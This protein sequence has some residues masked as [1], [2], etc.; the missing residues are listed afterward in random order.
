MDCPAGLVD[1][2]AGS[3]RFVPHFHLPLQHASDRMLAAMRRPYDFATYSRLVR[4]IHARLPHA[5]IG[6]DVIVGFPGE[7]D[8]DIDHALAVIPDLPLTSLHVFPYSDRPGTAA[9]ELTPKVA[10]AAITDRTRRLREVGRALSARFADSLAGTTRPGLTL[11]DGATVLTDN[12]VKVRIP[13]GLTRNVRVRV[14]IETVA[15]TLT[16]VVV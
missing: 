12:F 1:L 11:D 7:T 8:A 13:P 3:G 10:A 4:T 14:R 15:P 6:A 9:T 16:G 2:V 5:A